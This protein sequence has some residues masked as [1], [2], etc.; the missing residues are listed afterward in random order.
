M[1]NTVRTNLRRVPGQYLP[2]TSGPTPGK[3]ADQGPS[4]IDVGGANELLLTGLTN[5]TVYYVAVA[6]YD[7]FEPPLLSRFSAEAAAR[8]SAIRQLPVRTQGAEDASLAGMVWQ[9]QR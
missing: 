2:P 6:S 4:P 1:V 9:S 3:V 7:G 5:G 8:P